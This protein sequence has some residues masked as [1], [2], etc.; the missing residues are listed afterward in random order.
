MP[1]PNEKIIKFAPYV[2]NTIPNTAVFVSPEG[3]FAPMGDGTWPLHP[4]AFDKWTKEN[5]SWYD[6]SYIHAGLNPFPRFIIHGNEF[7]PF[8][9]TIS[10][11]TF[12]NFPIGKARHTV[13]CNEKGKIVLD[14]IVMRTG[15]EDYMAF[16]MPDFNMIN[17]QMGNPF[18]FDCK[19]VRD[20]YYFY[21]LCGPKSLEIVENAAKEDLHDIEFMYYKNATIAGHEVMILRTGMAGTLGYEVHGKIEDALDV[22]N[23]LLRV[24]K[25][26]G[27][28]ELGRIGYINAHCE[29]SIPQIAEHFCP[30]MDSYGQSY[31]KSG[32]L[33]PDHELWVR[34]PFD[35][36]WGNL[37]RFNHNFM[38]KEALMKEAESKAK[39]MV[40]LIWNRDDILKVVEASLDVEKQGDPIDMFCD[41]DFVRNC[42]GLHMDA[43]YDG[44]KFIGASSGRMTSAKT[45]EMISLCTI[46]ADYAVEGKEVEVLWGTP[47]TYQ[48]RVRAK[49]ML[50]PYNKVDRNES[51][52]LEKIPRYKG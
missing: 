42:N 5:T 21:Q 41:Y 14:G 23:E 2:N 40:H 28:Q 18:T 27:I 11:N 7:I 47:G 25:D 46:D 37:V 3:L 43:V 9:E 6:T 49:V 17:E 51:F 4:F 32:S 15:E 50:F 45:R 10:V 39:A 48:T 31:V 33:D 34:S 35:L 44:E 26:Y 29:G 16:C 20:D 36:G 30:D 38:G 19:A 8:L 13:L 12:R 24:G 52:D 1:H 22:Y